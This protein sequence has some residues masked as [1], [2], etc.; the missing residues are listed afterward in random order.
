MDWLEWA[1]RIAVALGGVVFLICFFLGA[2]S[3]VSAWR[4]T[5]EVW[6]AKRRFYAMQKAGKQYNDFIDKKIEDDDL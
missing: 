1:I 6:M 4:I 2:L 3:L 5:L